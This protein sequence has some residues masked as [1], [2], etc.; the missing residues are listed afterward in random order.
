VGKGKGGK[1]NGDGDWAM[2]R[3]A[4]AM[5]MA[6]RAMAKV[7]RAMATETTVAGN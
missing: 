6:A 3:T 4:R 1:R 2:A 7:A 5:A